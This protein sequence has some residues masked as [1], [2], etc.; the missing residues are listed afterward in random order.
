MFI[1]GR[2]AEPLRPLLI[3][4]KEKIPVSGTFGIYALER[5]LDAA[6]TAFLAAVGLLIFRP[7]GD[8]DAQTAAVAFE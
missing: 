2:A 4:R 6:C 8:Q 1:L 3:A 5:I 7:S